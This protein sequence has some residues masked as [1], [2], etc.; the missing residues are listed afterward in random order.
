MNFYYSR[1]DL[2][3]IIN[4]YRQEIDCIDHFRCDIH[5]SES[6]R[7]LSLF[8]FISTFTILNSLL[9]S[10][11]MFKLIFFYKIIY[12]LEILDWILTH[13]EVMHKWSELSIILSSFDFTRHIGPFKV[14]NCF[15]QA[16][17]V[18]FFFKINLFL[19]CKLKHHV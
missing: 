12:T 5:N 3:N 8:T 15:N 2:V 4:V 1:A 11:A 16:V 6:H 7:C 10:L 14:F 13:L 18:L 9:S 17:K 19:G